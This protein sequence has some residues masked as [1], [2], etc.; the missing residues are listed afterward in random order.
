MQHPGGVFTGFLGPFMAKTS[1]IGKIFE[2]LIK[3]RIVRFLEENNKLRDS[4]HG[5]R[6]KRSCL[7]NLLE[8][9]E[10]GGELCGS[11]SAGR[12]Q[13]IMDFQKVFE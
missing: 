8:F 6:A 11:G 7:L 5:F 9:F 12:T 10:F 2:R 13:C 4:Q 3:D 1:Q